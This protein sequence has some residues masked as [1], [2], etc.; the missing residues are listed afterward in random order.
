M[1]AQ[2]KQNIPKAMNFFHGVVVDERS[3]DGA[4]ILRQSKTFHQPWRVHMSIAYSDSG[5]SRSF[6]H[7]RRRRPSQIEAHS[8][9]S[10]VYPLFFAN[11]VNRCSG[12]AEYPK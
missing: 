11:A 12:F 7:G 8:W 4:A 6:R 2:I 9:H 5:A 10:L 3:A 1:S